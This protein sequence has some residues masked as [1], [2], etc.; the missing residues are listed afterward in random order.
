[1]E[2]A[3][4]YL[5]GLLSRLSEDENVSLRSMSD[6]SYLKKE[7][8]RNI[9]LLLNSRAHPRVDDLQGDRDL[10][11]SV[12]GMGIDDFCGLS[13]GQETLS[14]ILDNLREQVVFFEPRLDPASVQVKILEHEGSDNCAIDIEITARI[15]V[16]PFS[17]DINCVFSLDL[18]SGIPSAK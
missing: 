12:L 4:T 1:M 17:D 7:I 6:L 5:P 8:F 3:D 11:F 18:E 16:K 10:Y 9:E 13:H 14:R 2:R 15:N